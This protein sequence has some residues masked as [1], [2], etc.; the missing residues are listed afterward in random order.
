MTIKEIIELSKLGYSKQEIKELKEQET[1]AHDTPPEA[2][3]AQE[4]EQAPAPSEAPAWAVELNQNLARFTQTI[5][6]QNVLNSGGEAPASR[7]SNVDILGSLIGGK[8]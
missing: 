8:K 2:P 6:A 3:R 7:A 4:T 1:T 5:Q